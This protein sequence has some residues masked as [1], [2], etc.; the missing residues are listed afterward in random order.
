MN[1][2]EYILE[3]V[4]I[5]IS[6]IALGLAIALFLYLIGTAIGNGAEHCLY[7]LLGITMV[8]GSFM[9]VMNQ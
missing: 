5:V 9:T 4:I 1:K 7:L 3:Y 2:F 8:F 6:A